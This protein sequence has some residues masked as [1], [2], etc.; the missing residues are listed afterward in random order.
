[1][2]EPQ[3]GHLAMYQGPRFASWNRGVQWESRAKLTLSGEIGRVERLTYVAYE[4]Y[5]RRKALWKMHYRG[6]ASC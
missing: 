1:M 2:K 5:R 3:I 6:G 4:P